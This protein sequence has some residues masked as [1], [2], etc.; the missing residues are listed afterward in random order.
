MPSSDKPVC[1][2]TVKK[3]NFSYVN[4]KWLI[5][6]LLVFVGLI[7]LGLWQNERAL[8]KEQR[9]ASMALLKNQQ[10]ISLSEIVAMQKEQL[11]INDFPIA[12]NG[13]FEQ[14]FVF[15]LDNQVNN[16]SLGYK[17]LQVVES[18]SLSVLVNLG[19][20]EGS[21]DRQKIPEISPLSG[22]RKF[23]GKVRILEKGIMLMEQDYSTH[24]WP[25]RIQQIELDK[26]SL[27]INKPLVPF[28]VYVNDDEQIG[29]KKN[30]QPI[31]MPPEKH[32]AYAF[33]WFS[34]AIAWLILM[35]WVSGVIQRVSSILKLNKKTSHL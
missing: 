11:D 13:E 18:D 22:N 31:V 14:K 30:W 9:L 3:L 4:V 32:R 27:L 29:Y 34:L 7:K 19:W 23:E 2:K 21:I 15:L 24:K 8:E 16:G 35:L 17:V 20:I 10:A 6:T 1:S 25:L 5:F 28:I 12:V 33:Q 26:I